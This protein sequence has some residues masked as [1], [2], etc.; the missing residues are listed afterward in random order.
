MG[1]AELKNQFMN[2][3][4][5]DDDPKKN[6]ERYIELCKYA[7]LVQVTPA[8]VAALD[9]VSF[10]MRKSDTR[11]H[12]ARLFTLMETIHE[13]RQSYYEKA[14]QEFQ[15]NPGIITEPFYSVESDALSY[16][17]TTI[18]VPMGS[19]AVDGAQPKN[20]ADLTKKRWELLCAENGI[21]QDTDVREYA[22]RGPMLRQ[23]AYLR[24]HPELREAAAA[25]R[26]PLTWW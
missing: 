16:I 6:V 20:E 2:Y 15:G 7:C 1:I 18:I 11:E 21:P 4:F 5:S 3:V 14:I 19:P 24:A 12:R 13:K 23:Q 9:A 10:E 25:I 17:N 26:E 8:T 22:I